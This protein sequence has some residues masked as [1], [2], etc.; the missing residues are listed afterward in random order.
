MARPGSIPADIVTF[1]RHR[2][3]GATIEEIAA[4]LNEVRRF[5]VRQPSVRS[6]LYQHLGDKGEGLFRRVSRG[7]YALSK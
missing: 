2:S 7:H 1:L 5:E 4:A 3:D 6:A